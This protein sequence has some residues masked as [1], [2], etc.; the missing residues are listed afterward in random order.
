MRNHVPAWTTA[1][2]AC[3]T[4]VVIALSGCSDGES[5]TAVFTPSIGVS[6]DPAALTVQRGESGTATV[7]ISRRGGYT[8]TVALAVTGVPGGVT[9]TFDPSSVTGATSSTLTLDVASS[10]VE[11]TYPLTITGSGSS[12]A[13]QSATLTLTI[14]TPPPTPLVD[15]VL[16]APALALVQ[17]QSGTVSVTVSRGGGF[18]GSVALAVAGAPNGVTGTL[19]PTSVASAATSSI[20]TLAAA[21]DAVPGTYTIIVTGSGSGVASQ[22][23]SLTLTVSA[24]PPS[25]S[26]GLL[27]RA[28]NNQVS[29]VQGASAT[30]EVIVTRGGG[31]AGNVDLSIEGLPAGVTAQFVPPTIVAN[32]AGGALIFTA[33]AGAT[34]GS[35]DVTIR[36]R[37]IGVPDATLVVRLS[38]LPSSP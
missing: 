28:D 35:T 2:A 17:G 12:V 21:A 5:I 14:T 29:V 36:G 22:S 4:A 34:P 20:L 38:V 32:V 33:A 8:G 26:I 9:A 23:D 15:V 6:V 30:W 3:C 19:N 10:A 24:A 25:H 13:S 37:A 11:G 16:G 7:T 1:A 31:F 18:T 27:V